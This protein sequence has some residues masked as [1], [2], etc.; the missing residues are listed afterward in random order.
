RGGTCGVSD[1]HLTAATR[2]ECLRASLGRVGV[3][4]VSCS[5]NSGSVLPFHR[6]MRPVPASSPLDPALLSASHLR[7]RP[8]H[9]G[10]LD[11]FG[12]HPANTGGVK[13]GGAPPP[14]P[15]LGRWSSG[16]PPRPPMAASA[17]VMSATPYPV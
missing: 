9:P 3:A 15:C 10:R 14:E 13:R 17:A 8:L 6:R 1:G 5:P 12:Q 11:Q 7:K 16:R 4:L 2:A